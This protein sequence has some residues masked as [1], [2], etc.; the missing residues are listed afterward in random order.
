LD[1]TNASIVPVEKKEDFN[2][3]IG[4]DGAIRLYPF[5]FRGEGHF[6]CLIKSNDEY[7][8]N[9]KHNNKLAFRKDVELYRIFEKEYLNI[10][11]HGDFIRMGDEL[12]LLMKDCFNLDRLKILRNGLHLGTIKNNRFEP[13]HALAIYLKKEDV[14][15]YVSFNYDDKR[16]NDYLKGFT[17]DTI[18]KKGYILLCV[19]NVSLGWC[20]DDGRYLKNLYPKGLRILD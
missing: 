16:I 6:I 1:N 3:S 14:K 10:S 8:N 5:K 19:N 12:H 15:H 7:S 11:L 2:D 4:I 17:L 20:K 18:N 9:V 13:S